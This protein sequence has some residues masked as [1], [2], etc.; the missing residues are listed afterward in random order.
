MEYGVW[1]ASTRFMNLV[2]GG[3][4]D[5]GHVREFSRGSVLV[6]SGLFIGVVFIIVTRLLALGVK[7]GEL[8]G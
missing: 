2:I 5:D 8:E 6:W 3:W 4:H 1:T 7:G